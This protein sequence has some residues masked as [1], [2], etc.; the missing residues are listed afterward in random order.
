MHFRRY[1]I[2]EGSEKVQV[3]KAAAYLFGYKSTG[4]EG[5]QTST[6]EEEQK[7]ESIL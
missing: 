4:E 6:W 1:R 3:R 7:V 5:E 2:T